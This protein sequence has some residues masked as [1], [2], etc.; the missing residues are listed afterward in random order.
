MRGLLVCW[1]FARCSTQACV[2]SAR[3]H[4]IQE[5][6]ISSIDH[7]ANP[8]T[9]GPQAD[10]KQRETA[11]GEQIFGLAQI[12]TI[13]TSFKRE[14]SVRSI[15]RQIP[16]QS[17]LKPTKNSAKQPAVNKSSDLHRLRRFALHSR[18]NHQFDRLPGKSRHN[19]TSSRQK[20]ARNSPRN[21]S[22]DLHRLRRFALHSRENHQFDRS[23]SES[24]HNRTSS[25]QKTAR[26]SPRNKSSDLHRL[27]RFALHSRENHQFD[28]SPGKS[29][30]N[31][32]SSRQKTPRNSPRNKSSDLHRLRRFALHSRENHQFD[33]S[34]GK[35]R[36]NRTSTQPP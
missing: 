3:F 32:T 28:R 19:R 17:D 4:F 13:R 31:Q 18:E 21:K 27:R 26:N 15:T 30:H 20:T 35:S 5:R 11:R 23:P 2:R 12:A 16:T 24:R 36:H 7:L 1:R 10:K 6:I 9:I 29:R 33:R 25:R 8:D 22:S 14:S 34:P